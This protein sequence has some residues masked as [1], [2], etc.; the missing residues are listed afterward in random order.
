MGNYQMMDWSES[1][2]NFIGLI[3]FVIGSVFM[4]SFTSMTQTIFFKERFRE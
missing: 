2:I 3:I 1:D 4:W